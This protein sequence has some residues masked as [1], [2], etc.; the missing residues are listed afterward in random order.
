VTSTSACERARTALMASLDGESAPDSPMAHEHVSTCVACQRWLEDLQAMTTRLQDLS[1]PA[2]QSD[3][4]STVA[5]HIARDEGQPDLAGRL[6]PIAAIV[7][8][9]RALQLFVDLPMVMAH[10]LVPLA[11]AL[12]TAWLVTGDALAIQTSAPELQKR[13]A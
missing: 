6:W 13:G 2:V 12:A 1:Y 10:P 9:W 8:G 5:D 11:A 7:L 4:W 3:L